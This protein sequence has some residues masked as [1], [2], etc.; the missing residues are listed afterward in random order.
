MGKT[1]PRKEVNTARDNIL[2]LWWIRCYEWVEELDVSLGT[3]AMSIF[4]RIWTG[5]WSNLRGPQPCTWVCREFV[6]AYYFPICEKCIRI[7]RVARRATSWLVQASSQNMDWA[8][9]AHCTYCC[10][11]TGGHVGTSYGYSGTCEDMLGRLKDIQGRN[12]GPVRTCW[13]L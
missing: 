5:I 10:L 13:D 1:L 6:E 11:K 3:W 7:F 2:V 8:Y 4:Q 12:Q 9:F